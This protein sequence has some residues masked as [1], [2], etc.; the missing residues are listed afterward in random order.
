MIASLL[1]VQVNTPLQPRPTAAQ[2]K[3]WAAQTLCFCGKDGAELTL[4]LVDADESAALNAHY[5]HKTGPTNVLSFPYDP[6]F[7]SEHPG[8]G[9]HARIMGD[10]VICVP[11]VIQEALA[12]Q[13]TPE[14]HFA[15]M[16]VHGVLHVLGYDHETETDALVMQPLENKLLIQLGFD[17]PYG[18]SILQ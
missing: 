1:S 16:V 13:K 8:F 4:R 11:V 17:A 14:A 18:E 12:Q 10:I 3:H 6:L 2:L 15:H 9:E 5:R 7:T